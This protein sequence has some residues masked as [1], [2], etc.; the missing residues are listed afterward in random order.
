MS[1]KHVRFTIEEE[2]CEDCSQTRC[3]LRPPQRALDT[4]LREQRLA[5]AQ[6]QQMEESQPQQK[7]QQLQACEEERAGLKGTLKAKVEE[8]AKRRRSS[9]GSL[10][11]DDQQQQQQPEQQQQG[12]LEGCL[13]AVLP[14]QPRSLLR[15]SCRQAV[16]R[17]QRM[18]PRALA[19][20][21]CVHARHQR[22]CSSAGGVASWR[23]SGGPAGAGEAPALI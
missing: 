18:A 22:W 4:S 19:A 6:V 14:P 5:A 13:P 17:L 2:R 7:E 23:A 1:P 9:G 16:L 20:N 15:P 3:E 12:Q 10:P 21:T 11:S 8:E